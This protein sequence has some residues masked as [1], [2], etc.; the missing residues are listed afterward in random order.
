MSVRTHGMQWYGAGWLL[1]FPLDSVS[2]ARY[3]EH[4]RA[5]R[6]ECVCASLVAISPT[7]CGVATWLIYAL[8]CKVMICGRFYEVILLQRELFTLGAIIFLF[9]SAIYLSLSF[10]V[11]PL[12]RRSK[13]F[14]TMI[15][16]LWHG[17]WALKCA[18]KRAKNVKLTCVSIS[19]FAGGT[20]TMMDVWSCS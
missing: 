5:R 2:D 14:V 13:C 6:R 20:Y 17:R 11:Q 9:Q 4:S 3:G 18:Q 16:V 15:G 19:S 1:R 10:E 12:R 7:W 8:A